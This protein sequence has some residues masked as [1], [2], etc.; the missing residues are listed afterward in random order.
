M[1][2]PL[3]PGPE[4]A[5]GRHEGAQTRYW[6][7]TRRLTGAL[8]LLWL[9]LSLAASY[10]ARD[11]DFAFLGWRFSFWLGAQGALLAFLV[12]VVVYAVVMERI[13]KDAWGW[14]APP[15]KAHEHP[16][17]GSSAGTGRRLRDRLEQR[18]Q[19]TA[20]GGLPGGP[21]G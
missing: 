8:L 14:Q 12:I 17:G 6:R 18:P 21:A 15:D 13:E 11:V 20:P 3:Q 7:R 1:S 9:L 4:P 19:D 5:D 10:F 16:S 2:E